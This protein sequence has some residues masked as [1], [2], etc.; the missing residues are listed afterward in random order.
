MQPLNLFYEEPDPDRWLP[1]DRFA[2][3]I[4]RR[5]IRGRRRPGGQERVFLN[6]KAGLDK[7]SI[8]YRNNDHR[9]ARRNSDE[10]VCIVGKPHVLDRRDWQNP[11][12]FGAATFSHPIERPDFFNVYPTVRKILVPGEWMRR[13]WEPFYGSRVEAWP[14]GIDTARWAPFLG[15]REFDFLI[16]DKVRW[17]HEWYEK[18]LINPIRELLRRQNMSFREIRYGSYSEEDFE[19]A[20]Q[21]CRAM[22]FLC[23][24]ETQ[25]IAYQQALSAGVP[26]LAWDRGGFWQDPEF[27]PECVEFGSV[28]S[29][30][31][32][33]DRCGVKFSDAAAF[34]PKLEEFML[35]LG[36]G[37]LASRDYILENLT[38][39]MCA[40]RYL[41]IVREVEAT[42]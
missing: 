3:R 36:E 19:R 22:I 4:I 18:E 12:L 15:T 9:H 27:Y 8:R 35:A 26:I 38:L 5:T 28:S 34:L 39:E 31:Y 25:G 14:V 13:M 23:E 30:P 16:Y 21:Q 2:R 17:H 10:L 33:D 32:W 6:L 40:Q 37:R 1:Y 41:E 24:H 29:V 7:L 20:L 11:I 42:L